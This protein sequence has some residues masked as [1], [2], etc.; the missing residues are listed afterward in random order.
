[1]ESQNNPK[2]DPLL[3]WF[4]G[5][6]ACSSLFGLLMENGPFLVNDDGITLTYN[7]HSWNMVSEQ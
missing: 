3:I 5:G 4:N 2:T 7:P 1:M 6:P